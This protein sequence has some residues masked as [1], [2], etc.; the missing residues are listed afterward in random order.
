M[1]NFNYAGKKEQLDEIVSWFNQEDID[2]DEASE[3]FALAQK[4]I[5]EIDKYLSDKSAELKVKVDHK[6]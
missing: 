4:L 2:F 3:K 5:A 6:K 1:A